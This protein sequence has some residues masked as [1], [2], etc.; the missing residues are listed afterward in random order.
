MALPSHLYGDPAD[1]VKFEGERDTR[2]AEKRQQR[3]IR[4]SRRVGETLSGKRWISAREAAEA[5]FD[6]PQR[7]QSEA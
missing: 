3:E 5:L 7:P 1:H 4:E 6:L 2:A